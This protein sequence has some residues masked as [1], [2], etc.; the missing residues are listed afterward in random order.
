MADFRSGGSVLSWLRKLPFAEIILGSV[1]GEGTGAQMAM[2][3][4][5]LQQDTNVLLSRINRSLLCLQRI[6]SA[7]PL[8]TR[9]KWRRSYRLPHS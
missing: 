1:K 7:L 5:Q 4:L 8:V 3:P 2:F 6:R 9:A